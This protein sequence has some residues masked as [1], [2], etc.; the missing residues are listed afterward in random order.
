[1]NSLTPSTRKGTIKGVKSLTFFLPLALLALGFSLLP[2]NYITAQTTSTESHQEQPPLQPAVT[3]ALPVTGQA[4]E[5]LIATIKA[6]LIVLIRQLI[7][8]L[9]QEMQK[10]PS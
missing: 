10:I 1:M 2:Y 9:T 3:S 7:I 5:Q 4:R 8:L 6:Q